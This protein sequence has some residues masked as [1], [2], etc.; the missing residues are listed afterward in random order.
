MFQDLE[1]LEK[2]EKAEKFLKIMEDKDR[3]IQADH[4][5]RTIGIRYKTKTGRDYRDKVEFMVDTIRDKL[6][7]IKNYT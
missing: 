3:L 1:D 4:G 2:H 7:F 5:E 6:K